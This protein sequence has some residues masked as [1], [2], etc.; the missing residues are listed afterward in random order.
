MASCKAAIMA[1]SDGLS[2][3][4][5]NRSSTNFEGFDL[6]AFGGILALLLKSPG[7]RRDATPEIWASLSEFQLLAG[8]SSLRSS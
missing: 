5:S 1:V 2:F 4:V 8:L 7:A 6:T 3:A